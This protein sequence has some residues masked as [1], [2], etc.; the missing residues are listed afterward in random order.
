MSSDR[1]LFLQSIL[2]YHD[3]PLMWIETLDPKGHVRVCK[4]KPQDLQQNRKNWAA[5][6]AI[7]QE[8]IAELIA[9]AYTNRLKTH[10]LPKIV[11]KRALLVAFTKGVPIQLKELLAVSLMPADE[12]SYYPTLFAHHRLELSGLKQVICAPPTLASKFIR[13]TRIQTDKQ[14]L[15]YIQLD[16]RALS[17]IE[18]NEYRRLLTLAVLAHGAAYRELDQKTLYIPSFEKPFL[19]MAYDC[20][21]HL[22]EEG[23]KT[24]SL[25]PR[26]AWATPIYLC[27][28]TELWPSQRSNLES[29]LANFAENG[30]AT[31]AY[32]HSWRRIHKHLRELSTPYLKPIVVGHSMGGAL[33]IQT[34][35]YSHQLI[36]KAFAFNPTVPS[37]RDEEF[38]Q[39][40]SPELKLKLQVH[41]NLDDVAFWRIGE[42]VIGQVTLWFSTHRYPYYPIRWR[43]SLLFI[44]ALIK[45]GLNLVGV[46]P[47]HQKMFALEPIALSMKLSLSDLETENRDR[48]NRFDTLR[49]FPKLYDPLR[50]LIKG[51]R[52]I[53]GWSLLREY[54]ENEL[55]L[56][57][58]HE[59]EL[60]DALNET[61]KIE[62]E[63]EL[64][65]LS[66][67]KERINKEIINLK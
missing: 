25:K 62:I 8:P 55:E 59:L 49:F 3:R 5:L 48:Q 45:V 2:A 50:T 53:F 7:L 20:Q 66:I 18:D 44:P 30:P 34:G 27:Q 31:A 42:R 36:D 24:V 26:E 11:A 61:N 9:K 51:V 64:K 16:L 52:K 37:A 41:A 29:I 14:L 6:L 22:I 23:V 63:K 38:Y 1:E 39:K 47:T 65:A 21:Q 10:D 17:H 40:L 57:S 67:Q 46:F 32:A 56:I 28:G 58:L 35:L 33:A 54:L 13:H 43:D 60:K 12:P 19:L 4:K 15:D